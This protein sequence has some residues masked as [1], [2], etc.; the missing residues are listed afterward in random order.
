MTNKEQTFDDI[1]RD[2]FK[3]FKIENEKLSD[4]YYERLN[5]LIFAIRKEIDKGFAKV[6]SEKETA[7]GTVS[8]RIVRVRR[9]TCQNYK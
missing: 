9:G 7:V 2:A 6:M 4:D 3:N 1:V 8:P 5:Y